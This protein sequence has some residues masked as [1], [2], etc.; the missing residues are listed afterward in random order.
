[1][2]ENKAH[3]YANKNGMEKIAGTLMNEERPMKEAEIN[4]SEQPKAEVRLICLDIDGTL[5]NS[6]QEITR[7]TREAVNLARGRGIHVTIAT[8]RMFG[9]AAGPARELEIVEPLITLNGACMRKLEEETGLRDLPMDRKT[10]GEAVKALLELGLKPS[11]YSGHT[12]YIG[13][14][15]ERYQKM[16]ERMGDPR[17]RIQIIDA[18]YRFEDMLRERDLRIRKGILFPQPGQ[19]EA[20]WHALKKIPGLSVV[21]S[22]SETIEFSHR[23]ANKGSAVLQLAKR[24][25]VGPGEIMAI[26]DSDND[27]SMLNVAGF[28]VAMGNASEAIRNTARFVTEDNDNNGVA[29]AIRRHALGEIC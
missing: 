2:N 12:L 16:L 10:L 24:L 6:G 25:S 17:Y 26:G 15:L 9:S 14:R 29:R 23:E 7:E 8:G 22:S 21:S 13:D 27:L 11:F 19:Q 18:R 4:T 20:A 1:M 28:S 5:L 3:H